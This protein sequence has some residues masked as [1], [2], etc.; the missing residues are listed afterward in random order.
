MDGPAVSSVRLLPFLSRQ[1]PV[2]GK[3][4]DCLT[5]S[6]GHRSEFLERKGSCQWP[7]RDHRTGGDPHV[8]NLLGLCLSWVVHSAAVW[9]GS[10][11]S[12]QGSALVDQDIAQWMSLGSAGAQDVPMPCLTPLWDPVTADKSSY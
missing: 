11:P 4:T 9:Q 12:D 1:G 7:G 8:W 2:R 5:S 6:S 3:R 10:W